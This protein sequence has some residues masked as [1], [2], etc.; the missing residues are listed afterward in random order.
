[1][2]PEQLDF[3]S[4][5]KPYSGWSLASQEIPRLPALLHPPLVPLLKPV[6]QLMN[7]LNRIQY[8]ELTI[9]GLEN[10]PKPKEGGIIFASNHLSFLDPQPST[11]NSQH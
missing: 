2:K 7:L 5:L 1:M 3:F 6:V 11:L 4:D 9:M 10:L 8:R